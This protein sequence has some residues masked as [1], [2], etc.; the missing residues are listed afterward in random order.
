MIKYIVIIVILLILS[1]GIVFGITTMGCMVSKIERP[2]TPSCCQ[3]IY[4]I[5]FMGQT[6]KQIPDISKFMDCCRI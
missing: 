5:M 1:S 4:D 6:F 2:G 3:R